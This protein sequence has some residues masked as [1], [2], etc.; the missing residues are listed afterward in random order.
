MIENLMKFCKGI[1]VTKGM[2]EE[3]NRTE[4]RRR[5]IKK[6]FIKEAV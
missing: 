3:A 2:T 1:P 5:Q 4:K 6:A